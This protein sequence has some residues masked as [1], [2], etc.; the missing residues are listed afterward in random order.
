[1]AYVS[2]GFTT[3]VAPP[4]HMVQQVDKI[5]SNLPG[6][7]VAIGPRDACPSNRDPLEWTISLSALHAYFRLRRPF[8]LV[9]Q[10]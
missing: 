8:G 2:A 7:M 10:T 4:N 5:L 1:M 3:T 9:T 6:T